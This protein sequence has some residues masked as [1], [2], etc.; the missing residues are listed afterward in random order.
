MFLVS[1]LHT[2]IFYL[3]GRCVCVYVRTIRLVSSFLQ[4]AAADSRVCFSPELPSLNHPQ[5][6][7]KNVQL[8]VIWSL[9][10]SLTCPF[11][12]TE[13]GRKKNNNCQDNLRAVYSV[14]IVQCTHPSQTFTLIALGSFLHEIQNN[15][16]IFIVTK[17]ALFCSLL[18]ASCYFS[19]ISSMALPL[20]A[21]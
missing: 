21:M 10:N 5:H 20:T 3:W 4:A 12:E 17:E 7:W 11:N 15:C 14:Y 18:H 2:A 13:A 1:D 6:E 9:F 16:I 19:G 8:S